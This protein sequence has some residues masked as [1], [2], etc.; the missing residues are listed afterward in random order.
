MAGRLRSTRSWFATSMMLPP[1]HPLELG[2][3]LALLCGLVLLCRLRPGQLQG[4]LLAQPLRLP[5]SGLRLPA[6]GRL[7]LHLERS[8]FLLRRSLARLQVEWEPK[9]Q[10]IENHHNAQWALL[11]YGSGA[12]AACRWRS[13][14][15][16]AG[17]SRSRPMHGPNHRLTPTCAPPPPAS[18]TK[19]P[20][21]P[22]RP[23]AAAAHLLQR[24]LP[25]LLGLRL[26]L[27]LRHSPR[28]QLLPRAALRHHHL[29][30]LAGPGCNV[31]LELVEASLALALLALQRPA[32][33]SARGGLG[34]R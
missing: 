21:A 30:H 24:S 3:L 6:A 15:E 5:G 17:D 16:A 4:S 14:R 19:P 27:G 9:R 26:R 22:C 10:G 18:A 29:A 20:G 31:A 32:G 12:A 1:C 8:H 25:A 13:R 2:V 7:V 11:S 28:L 34:T 23:A 33:R